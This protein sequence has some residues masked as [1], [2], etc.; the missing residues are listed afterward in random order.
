MTIFKEMEEMWDKWVGKKEKQIVP[1]KFNKIKILEKHNLIGRMEESKD[2]EAPPLSQ[3]EE[4]SLKMQ[5]I[6]HQLI[7]VIEQDLMEILRQL[8]AIYRILDR[9]MKE[10]DK[11]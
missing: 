2:K 1:Y 10:R 11:E 8:E 6:N 7:G 4:M 5:N 3:Y 9:F